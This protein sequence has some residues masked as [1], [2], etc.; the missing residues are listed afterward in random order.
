MSHHGISTNM[1][2]SQVALLLLTDL[3][4]G[5]QHP[6]TLSRSAAPTNPIEERSEE[7]SAQE[8][9]RDW[10][11]L[12]CPDSKEKSAEAGI[13]TCD[14]LSLFPVHRIGQMEPDTLC[15]CHYILLLSLF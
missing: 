11:L 9:T 14:I 4:R 7:D 15:G 5:A 12:S 1:G 6:K 2:N 3:R 10:H 13:L 8:N